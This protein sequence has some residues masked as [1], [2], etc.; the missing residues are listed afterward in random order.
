MAFGRRIGKRDTRI[1]VLTPT[2]PGSTQGYYDEDGFLVTTEDSSRFIWAE[3]KDRASIGG[4]IG[5]KI[6]SEVELGLMV[7][8]L[9]ART[10]NIMDTITTDRDSN[11]YQVV[12]VYDVDYRYTSMILVRREQ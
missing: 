2:N 9:T 3:V 8:S 10:I 1:T 6:Q 7:D 4:I 12:D 5:G 11:R